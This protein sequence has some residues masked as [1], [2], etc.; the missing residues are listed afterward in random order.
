MNFGTMPVVVVADSKW[1]SHKAWDMDTIVG[2]QG[3]KVGGSYTEASSYT[4]AIWVR[5]RESNHGWRTF[6]RHTDDH[7]EIVKSG[8][9]ELGNFENGRASAFH[10]TRSNVVPGADVLL[11]AVAEG[12][13]TTFY[14]DGVYKGSSP[15]VCSGNGY[16]RFGW[17]GQGPG[18]IFRVVTWNTALADNYV[19]QLGRV[20]LG[21]SAA[22]IAPT[23]VKQ[24][25]SGYFTAPEQRVYKAQFRKFGES[26]RP[27]GY[28]KPRLY[29]Y[30]GKKV[31]SYPELWKKTDM[32]DATMSVPANWT[33]PTMWP[34]PSTKAPT[35]G[36]EIPSFNE[37]TYAS[38][39][40]N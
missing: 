13:K 28:G 7:C 15:K 29:T 4:H 6:F 14:V 12:E 25:S 9:T 23:V 5:L 32:E 8:S 3:A 31:P 18:K 22:D 21:R 36:A 2:S 10:G 30:V 16:L 40:F 17:P 39:Y 37:K 26:N 33:F 19:V 20:A 11:V 27:E 1:G 35:G 24:P 34:T 38:H